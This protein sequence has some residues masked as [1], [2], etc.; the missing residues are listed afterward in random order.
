MFRDVRVVII[1]FVAD[2]IL[3]AW[4]CVFKRLDISLFIINVYHNDLLKYS[5]LAALKM[6]ELV[7]WAYKGKII[8]V[9]VV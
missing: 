3:S 7:T 2:G 4:R 8:G 9:W 1:L 5:S 6:P